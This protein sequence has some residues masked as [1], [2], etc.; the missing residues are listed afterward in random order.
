MMAIA[1]AFRKRC[2]VAWMQ[3]RFTAIF[4]ERHFAFEHINELILVAVPV[5]LA[6]PAAGRQG[7]HIDAEIA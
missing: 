2:A 3:Q 4:D 7:H 6:G 5:A 1:A